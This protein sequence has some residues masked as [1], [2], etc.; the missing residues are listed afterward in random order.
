MKLY[1]NETGITFPGSQV[2][3]LSGYTF[4][5]TTGKKAFLVGLENKYSL[6]Q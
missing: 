3:F 4:Y 1:C 6:L 2:V 5:F